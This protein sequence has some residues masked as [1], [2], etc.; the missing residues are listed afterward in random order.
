[1][2]ILTVLNRKEI[3][4][5]KIFY[6]MELFKSFKNVYLFGSIISDKKNP[7][8]IDLLLIYEDFSNALLRDLDEI[9]TIFEK[10][11]GFSFDLNVL[12]EKEEKE[13]NFLSKLKT[14]YLRLK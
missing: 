10:L 6:H 3:V 4:I 2:D 8:D 5:Q 12:S 7:N 11:Y 13:S 14:N 9:R 1:M